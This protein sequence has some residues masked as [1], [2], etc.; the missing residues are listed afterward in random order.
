M[1]NIHDPGTEGFRLRKVSEN[2]LDIENASE[3]GI[4]PDLG[5]DVE[6][7]VVVVLDVVLPEV[8]AEADVLGSDKGFGLEL[9]SI[10]FGI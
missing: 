2:S 6:L 4:P 8:E 10:P 5:V 9:A 1:E 7:A 3:K